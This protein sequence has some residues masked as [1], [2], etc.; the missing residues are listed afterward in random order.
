MSMTISDRIEKGIG[1][2]MEIKFNIRA[3]GMSEADAIAAVVDRVAAEEAMT[4]PEINSYTSALTSIC[5]GNWWNA[6]ARRGQ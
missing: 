3:L 5:T 1:D 4:Q 2:L 6:R